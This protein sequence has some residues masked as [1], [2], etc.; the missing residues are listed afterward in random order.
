MP[1]VSE[2]LLD[3]ACGRNG[4]HANQY[5]NHMGDT[6]SRRTGKSSAGTMWCCE[7]HENRPP[8]GCQRF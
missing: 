6:Q 8:E 2:E 5:R 1:L 3:A 4:K 7:T